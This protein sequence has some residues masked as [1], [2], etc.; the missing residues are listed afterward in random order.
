MEKAL[1]TAH[2]LLCLVTLYTDLWI[3]FSDQACS[4]V[5]KLDGQSLSTACPVKTLDKAQWVE[6][7]DWASFTCSLEKSGRSHFFGFVFVL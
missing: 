1:P 7:E 3:P 6:M 5:V 2:Y 4:P